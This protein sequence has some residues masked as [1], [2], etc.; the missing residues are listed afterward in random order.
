MNA[1]ADQRYANALKD[2][3]TNAAIYQAYGMA[4][5]PPP[6][7]AAHITLHVVCADSTGTVVPPPQGADGLHYAWIW[8]T[9]E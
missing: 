9:P 7:K 5:P 3:L 6:A 1:A 2:W 4:I 8:E